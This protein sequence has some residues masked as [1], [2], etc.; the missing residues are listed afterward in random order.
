MDRSTKIIEYSEKMNRLY[1]EEDLN[2]AIATWKKEAE[3]AWRNVH[4]LEKARIEEQRK[5]DDSEVI[6][7]RLREILTN[8]S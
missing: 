3:T 1:T 6:L 5:R 7:H 2:D 4:I 8:K